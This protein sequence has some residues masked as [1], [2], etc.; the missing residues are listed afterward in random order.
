MFTF[1]DT[2]CIVLFVEYIRTV[3]VQTKYEQ[4]ITSVRLYNVHIDSVNFTHRATSLLHVCRAVKLT[5][6]Q[7]CEQ[8][9]LH[10]YKYL[11]DYRQHPA[12]R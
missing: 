5:L 12:E 11:I 6:R 8:T 2:L 3:E 9:T 4:V 7:F 10:G 1:T